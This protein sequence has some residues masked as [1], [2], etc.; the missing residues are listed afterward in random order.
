MVNR[1]CYVGMRLTFQEIQFADYAA[2]V[3][4][5]VKYSE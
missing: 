4:M 5:I 3:E 2:A 1:I